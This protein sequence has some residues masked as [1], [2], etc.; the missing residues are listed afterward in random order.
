MSWR[1]VERRAKR[2]GACCSG[3]SSTD[4]FPPYFLYF[5]SSWNDTEASNIKNN[6]V[7]DKAKDVCAVNQSIVSIYMTHALSV[8]SKNM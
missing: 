7:E 6:A 4:Y 5:F 1:A 3:L 8:H 2:K